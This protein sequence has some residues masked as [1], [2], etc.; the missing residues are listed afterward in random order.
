MTDDK[1]KMEEKLS[2]LGY[3]TLNNDDDTYN[4]WQ[5]MYYE[6]KN[7][8]HICTLIL[9]SLTE[10]KRSNR[11]KY[12]KKIIESESLGNTHLYIVS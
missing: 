8:L 2:K 10:K 3:F 9:L 5:G 4:E 12:Q 7:F 6:H 11:P 1:K